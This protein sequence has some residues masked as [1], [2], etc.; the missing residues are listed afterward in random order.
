MQ[1]KQEVP[2]NLLVEPTMVERREKSRIYDPFP[3][4]VSGVDVSGT[5]F[6]SKTTIDNIS[7]SGL[8][9]RL[10]QRPEQRT[11]LYIVVQLSNALI[12]GESLM[13]LHLSGEVLRVEPR[14]GGACGLAISI[15]HNRLV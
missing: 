7:T 1:N 4:I 8:Y 13:S 5:T 11:K 3:A 9:L 6:K 14:L 2:D 10:M 15:K 12:D